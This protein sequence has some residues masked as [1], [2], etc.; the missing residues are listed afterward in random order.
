MANIGIAGSQ[1]TGRSGSGGSGSSNSSLAVNQTGHGFSVGN[2]IYFNGTSWAKAEANSPSTLG[3]GIVTIVSGANDFTVFFDGFVSGLSGF[4]AGQY[5]FVSDATPGLLTSTE[6]SANTS[7]SNPLF[8]ALSASS[9]IVLPFRPSAIFGN[10]SAVLAGTTVVQSTPLNSTDFG[11]AN[12][13]IIIAMPA[14]AL[15]C[16]PANW[17][18]SIILESGASYVVGAGV[19]YACAKNTGTISSVTTITWGSSPTPTLTTGEQ[20][21]DPIALP[22]DTNHDYFIVIYFA[23]GSG[24]VGTA[25]STFGQPWL[26]MTTT[27]GT[28][29]DYYGYK[30]GNQTTATVTNPVPASWSKTEWYLSQCIAA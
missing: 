21:S 12:F 2:A 25:T 4:T 3:T 23:S 28:A 5:Y 6:P 16:M 10:G 30:S 1:I 11:F 15:M 24:N 19:V 26:A 8:F 7:Y 13:S 27:A 29:P 17:K 14:G 20:F 18:F 9:G 22:L